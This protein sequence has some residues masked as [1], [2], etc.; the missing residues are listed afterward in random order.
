MEWLLLFS[1]IGFIIW[2]ILKGVSAE[3]KKPR[4]TVTTTVTDDSEDGQRRARGE[5]NQ[6]HDNWEGS[7]WNVQSPRNISADLRIDYRD[8]VG[9]SSTRNIRLMKY[10]AWEGGAILWAYCHLRQANRTFRTDRIISCTDLNS[11]EII[12]NLEAWLDE[13]YQASP[14]HA[15]EKIVETAWDALRVLYYVGKADGRL[16]QKERVIVRDAV[17]S[18]SDHTAIDDTRIDE[19]LDSIDNPSVTAFKQ[20][21]GRL[22]KHNRELAIK[23]ASWSAT[24][25][26]TEKTIS[27]VEQ[28]ALEYF[29]TVLNK[30]AA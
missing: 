6:E 28:D 23:V 9:S 11:G 24:M 3:N 8:G 17:R 10:G 25:V 29:K 12:E 19:M 1:F 27:T 26:A 20:A 16:T 5:P 2:Q 4:L 30:P 7:F 15:L 21:F 13:K 18:M 14:E 22:A